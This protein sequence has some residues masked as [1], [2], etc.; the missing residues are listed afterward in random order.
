M[1][2]D[3]PLPIDP[4]AAAFARVTARMRAAGPLE[5]RQADGRSIRLVVAIS[6][7]LLWIGMLLAIACSI[8]ACM[9]L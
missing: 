4:V 5:A 7:V 6:N 2:G 9:Q 1:V 3:D 8:Y